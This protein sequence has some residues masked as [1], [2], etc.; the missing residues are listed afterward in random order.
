M[1]CQLFFL[2]LHILYFFV[3]FFLVYRNFFLV[4][5]LTLC[6]MCCKYFFSLLLA[7]LF[8]LGNLASLRNT[9]FPSPNL[10]FSFIAAGFPV[11]SRLKN[12]SS[13]FSSSI[14]VLIFHFTSLI[15]LGLALQVVSGGKE[16]FGSIFFQMDRSRTFT[17][18]MREE[19][20]SLFQQIC[21]SEEQAR[22][23]G[24]GLTT[25]GEEPV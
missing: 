4:R 22:A 20:F 15:H 7:S 13:K 25:T 9:F 12:Q 17:P 10:S 2:L 6:Y 21:C 23:A 3:F 18:A 14:S 8:C 1:F 19:K 5:I 16:G 11:P 24:S